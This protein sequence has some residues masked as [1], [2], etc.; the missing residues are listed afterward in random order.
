MAR[1]IMVDKID[2]AYTVKLVQLDDADLPEG[3]VTVDISYSALNYKDCLAITGK[4]PV[5]RK[6]PM[7]PGVD[8]AG[9]VETSTHPEFRVG[10]EVMNGAIRSLTKQR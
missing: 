8:L 10:D 3:D 6:F 9:T 4:G 2:G 7:V 1:A 5:V